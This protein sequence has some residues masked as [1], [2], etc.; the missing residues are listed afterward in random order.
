M[1]MWNGILYLLGAAVMLKVIKYVLIR[2]KY[3]FIVQNSIN[4]IE[5]GLVSRRDLSD[6]SNSRFVI[7]C[8][9]ILE[10][11]GF[12]NIQIITKNLENSYQFQGYINGR[13]SY[14]K[15][16]KADHSSSASKDEDDLSVVGKSEL[17]EFIGTMEQD[18]V[19][20]GYILTN[21]NFS[22]TAYEF[23]ATM[24]TEYFIRLVDGCELTRLHRRNQKQYLTPN[25]D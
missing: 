1:N 22:K 13:R 21:G 18:K 3:S 20:L 12:H 15:C 7:W 5:Y 4:K 14:I 10:T 2:Y 16:I 25:L 19:K 6:A 9:G 17:Q 23:A 11:L 24:P 8:T